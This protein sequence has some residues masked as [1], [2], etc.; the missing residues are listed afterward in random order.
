MPEKLLINSF[1]EKHLSPYLNF[2]RPGAIPE[3][4]KDTRGK[5]KRMYTRYAAP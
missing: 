1:F 2:H 5:T 3:L 4:K